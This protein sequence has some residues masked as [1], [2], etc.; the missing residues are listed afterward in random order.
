MLAAAA[1]S[2]VVPVFEFND[3]KEHFAVIAHLVRDGSYP[4]YRPGHYEQARQETSQPPLY[5]W[6]CS[7]LA[8]GMDAS[9]FGRYIRVNPRFNFAPHLWVLHRYL[10]P[11]IRRSGSDFRIIGRRW[12]FIC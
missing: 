10:L 5:Y 2:V 9:D 4:V 12:P 11:G 6:L 3:E 8:K 7:V 1:Y